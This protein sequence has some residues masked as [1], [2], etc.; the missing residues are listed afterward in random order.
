MT[1]RSVLQPFDHS[2]PEERVSR[3]GSCWIEAEA[4]PRRR[5][6]G[7]TCRGRPTGS[8]QTKRFSSHCGVVG[9]GHGLNGKNGRSCS[10]EEPFSS[11]VNKGTTADIPRGPAKSSNR[12][13]LRRAL[14]QRVPR[15]TRGEAL[16]T[17]DGPAAPLGPTCP[18]AGSPGSQGT[19]TVLKRTVA[20]PMWNALVDIPGGCHV[21][22][23]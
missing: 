9:V 10:P 1:A 15:S 22:T 19:R 12:T 6:A 11:G 21:H 20:M 17:G 5:L 13:R 8:R 4:N 23:R 14:R 18:V 3:R 2:T 7:L 16:R